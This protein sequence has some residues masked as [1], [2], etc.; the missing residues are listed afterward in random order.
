MYKNKN[1]DISKENKISIAI[2]MPQYLPVPAVKG[3]AIETLASLLLEQNEGNNELS[4]DLFS[5]YDKNAEDAAVKYQKSN[6]IYIRK[7]TTI[8]EKI[9][10]LIRFILKKIVDNAIISNNYY[11]KVFKGCKKKKY[12]FIIAEGGNADLFRKFSYEFGKDKLILHIHVHYLC[13]RIVQGIF[14]ATISTSKFINDEWVKSYHDIDQKN[15]I[16]KNVVDE[17]QFNKLI[18]MNERKE[19]RNHLGFNDKD[20]IIIYCG[21]ITE[22]KG[23]KELINAFSKIETS[24]IKL[25]VIGGAEFGNEEKQTRY[26]KEVRDLVKEKTE[27]IKMI[28]YIDNREM[29]KY[30][31]IADV[32]VIPSL[33]EEAA[34]LVTIEGMYSG[35]PLIITESGGMVEYVNENCAIIVKRDQLMEENLV[36]AI[37][38][39]YMDNELRQKMSRE[40]EKTAKLYTKQRYYDEYI[41]VLKKLKELGNKNNAKGNKK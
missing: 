13:G 8:F 18:S 34:G 25:L 33:C 37:I 4:I 38:K 15:F 41:G 29:Y 24:N 22:V 7:N 12:D 26:E 10:H 11:Y 6:I 36:N 14:G 19:L 16:V 35:L 17:E 1:F 27:K 5:V 32:Q 40:A 31:Q 9:S 30:Y 20:F 2:V 23:V 3:G 21:R 28:G 39:L